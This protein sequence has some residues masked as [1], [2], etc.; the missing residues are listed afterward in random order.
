MS[1]M[2]ILFIYLVV[3]PS[4]Y[5][6]FYADNWYYSMCVET[7][8]LPKNVERERKESKKK[9]NIISV[10]ETNTMRT[11]RAKVGTYGFN[12]QQHKRTHIEYDIAMP[13]SHT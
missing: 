5:T 1:T 3:E 7:R 12:L 8:D 6:L 2:C 11:K 9:K 13:F 10:Y 4:R